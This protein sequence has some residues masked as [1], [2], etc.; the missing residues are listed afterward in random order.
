MVPDSEARKLLIVDTSVLLYDK[1]SII[2]MTGNDVYIPLVVLEELDKFKDKSGI[3]GESARHINRFLDSLRSVGN[4]H[5]GIFL[6]E[7]DVFI[8]VWTE[9]DLE[10]KFYRINKHSN[11]NVILAA[12]K[13][14][15]AKNKDNSLN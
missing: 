13:D 5:S 15:Y 8:K 9:I 10:T 2:R 11:D 4:L 14:I 7:Y 6:E 1:D 12:V 3:L